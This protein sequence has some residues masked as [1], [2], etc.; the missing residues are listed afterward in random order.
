MERLEAKK[1][2]IPPGTL[3][4]LILRTLERGPQHGYGIAEHIHRISNDVLAVEEGSLYPA[5]QRMQVKGWLEAS[6]AVTPNNRR[7]RYYRLTPSGMQQLA[8]E[9][10]RFERVT[11]AISR[12]LQGA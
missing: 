12:V 5:L 6:W 1:D 9:R 3:A 2:E 7:A 11:G 4:L 8:E 10:Q